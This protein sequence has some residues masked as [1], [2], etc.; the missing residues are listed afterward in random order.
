[1]HPRKTD[2]RNFNN[3]S[4]GYYLLDLIEIV[5]DET[6]DAVKKYKKSPF[7]E[8]KDKNYDKGYSAGFVSGCAFGYSRVISLM[9]QQADAFNIPRSDLGLES[10]D[11]HRD[12]SPGGW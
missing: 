9:L 12:L 11:P 2:T 1:M 5:K 10:I 8:N 3:P 7:K 4:L 6:F